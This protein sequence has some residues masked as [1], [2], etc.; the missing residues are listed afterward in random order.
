MVARNFAQSEKETV[1]EGPPLSSAWPSEELVV[2]GGEA[3]EAA[4]SEP[5]AAEL[6]PERELGATTA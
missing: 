5:P 6:D 2:G 1:D 4:P 3:T